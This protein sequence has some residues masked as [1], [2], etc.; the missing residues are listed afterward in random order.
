MY[1]AD[2]AG[3]AL[4]LCREGLELDPD[5]PALNRLAAIVAARAGEGEAS[6]EYT[7]RAVAARGKSCPPCAEAYER[8]IKRAI[9]TW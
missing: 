6:K 5:H 4:A 2:D 1:G 3:Q 8:Y 9:E 7:E